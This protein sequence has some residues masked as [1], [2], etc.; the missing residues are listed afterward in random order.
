MLKLI[1]DYVIVV[2]VIFAGI[3]IAIG[4]LILIV[5]SLKDFFFGTEN[6]C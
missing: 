1:M 4:L 2:A 5:S 6:L 3:S